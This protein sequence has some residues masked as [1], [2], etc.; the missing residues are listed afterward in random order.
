MPWL[1]RLAQNAD[2]LSVGDGAV[3]VPFSFCASA[4]LLVG[5]LA[6]LCVAVW[7]VLEARDE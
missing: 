5:T 2:G 3:F 4:L 6:V 1:V 7:R